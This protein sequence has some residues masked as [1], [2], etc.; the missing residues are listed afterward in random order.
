MCDRAG[1]SR[2]MLSPEE[3]NRHF[4]D[5]CHCL[6]RETENNGIDERDRDWQLTIAFMK[7][8]HKKTRQAVRRGQR[9]YMCVL[10]L[11][12]ITGTGSPGI[13]TRIIS[14]VDTWSRLLGWLEL[15]IQQIDADGR[16]LIRLRGWRGV[17]DT[18]IFPAMS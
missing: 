14:A 2:L 18:S 16:F 9:S 1:V 4:I 15:S 8:I 5:F 11:P 10:H 12:G 17:D 3:L 7:L 13:S 6:S